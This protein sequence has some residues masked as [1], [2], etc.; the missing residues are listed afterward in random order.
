MK[1]LKALHGLILLFFVATG[2][3]NASELL[4]VAEQLPPIHFSNSQNQAD[5]FLVELAKVTAQ[6]AGFTAKIALMPQA[7]A[8]EH[9][10]TGHNVFMLSLLRSEQREQEF[11]WVGAVYETRA[12][13]IGLSQRNDIQLTTLDDAKNFVV[14]TV[15]G[16]FS[17]TWLR[18]K[19]FSDKHNL[20]LAV[21]YDHLW[22]MLFKQHVDLVLTNALS[23]ELEIN[24]AGY[25]AEEV[26]RYL[27]LP[28]LTREL[29][30]AAGAKT[31]KRTVKK[32]SEALV[33]IK[34][35]GTY[36]ALKAKWLK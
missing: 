21:Q 18:Q 15:R 10:T 9:T 25:K 16:Y 4:F 26:T 22:G 32:L 24:K 34:A 30:F 5:G 28:E 14:G 11:Q 13:L 33:E 29:H 3:V 17:E 12:Y 27:A 23:Q 35:D 2:K 6:K 31:D 1:A 7:R 8:F 36:Q 20:G 19:G